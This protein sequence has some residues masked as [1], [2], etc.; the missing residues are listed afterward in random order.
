MEALNTKDCRHEFADFGVTYCLRRNMERYYQDCIMNEIEQPFAD[1][2]LIVDEVDDLIVDEAPNQPFACSDNEEPSFVEACNYFKREG[3]H[4]DGQ[5]TFLWELARNAGDS[6]SAFRENEDYIRQGDKFFLLDERRRPL[7]VYDYKLEYL[8]PN[9]KLRTNYY[10]QSIPYM[11]SQYE[12]ITGF[13]GSLGS[14]SEREY[15]EKQY[16]AWCFDTPSFLNTCKDVVKVPPQLMDDPAKRG[17]PCV[18]VFPNQTEQI[19]KIVQIA[20]R[21]H[22]RVAVLI[23]AS[24]TAEAYLI[25]DEVEK[26]LRETPHVGCDDERAL[27]QG[28]QEK[29]CVQPFLQFVRDTMVPDKENWGRIISRATQRLEDRFPITVTDP[30]GGR[31]HDFDVHDDDVESNG[32]LAVIMTSIPASDREWRQW[33]GRTGRRDNSG[34]YSVVLCAEDALLK[35]AVTAGVLRDC[36]P[37]EDRNTTRYAEKLITQLLDL[38]D[39][40]QK[41]KLRN[42]E[43]TIYFGRRLNRLCDEFY[44]SYGSMSDTNWPKSDEEVKLRK[45]YDY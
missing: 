42:L 45:S 28:F 6:A 39:R 2:V 17:K 14:P 30:F 29:D 27:I 3:L 22:I 24:T 9:P 44:L 25:A 10:Y 36:Q 37:E 18:H 12:C 26:Y 11:L 38:Q 4:A 23:I 19:R 43:K 13:S 40:S 21:M 15:L 7:D 20:A 33:K 32:G 41:D 5:M 8:K 35:E 34:Q 1:T 31:G 16:K